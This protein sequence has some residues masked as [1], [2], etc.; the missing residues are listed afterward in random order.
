MNPQNR[1]LFLLVIAGVFFWSVMMLT[2]LKKP[3]KTISFKEFVEYAD[4]GRVKDV[5]IRQNGAMF[6]KFK[7]ND[8]KD[9]SNVD[10][11]GDELGYYNFE[12]FVDTSSPILFE[13]LKRNNIVPNYE[14]QPSSGF[15]NL[16]FLLVMFGLL[17]WVL[18]GSI[19]KS[20]MG[21]G[22]AISTFVK[23]RVKTTTGKEKRVLF[24]DVAGVD[25]AKEE[26]KEVV[27]FLKYPS[28]FTKLGGR[29]PKGVLL[30]GPPGTGKTLLARAV[31]G[32]ANVPFFFISGSDFVEMFVGVG[33]SRVRELF[34]QGKKNAP[35]IIFIDEIDAVGRQRGVGFSGG[36]DEREQTLNQML[37]EM[38]G[39]DN[40]TGVIVVAATNRSDVLDQALLRP[41]RFDRQVV[42][43]LP[44]LKGREEIFKVHTAKKPLHD[45]VSLNILA[46][47]TPGFS[48]ADIENLVNESALCAARKNRTEI[49]MDDFQYAID[50]VLMGLERKSLIMNDFEKKV[51]AYHEAGHA[52]VGKMV[53][54]VDPIHKVTIIPRGMALGVTQT[55]PEEDR[56]SLTKNRAEDNIAF[57]MGGRV[58]EELII[59]E[60][61]TGASN[62]IERATSLARKMICEW[63]LSKAMGPINYSSERSGFL[64]VPQNELS[65]ETKKAIEKEVKDII[66]C[67]YQ[68][69]KEILTKNINSL[70]AIALALFEKETITGEEIDELIKTSN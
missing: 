23:S 54:N 36:H 30:S 1:S 21:G 3:V 43:S 14:L 69:A 68:R 39:F 53:K 34:E 70:H 38:D 15:G 8:S 58:A 26:L 44:T 66:D 45:S 17:Y 67:N 55:L 13:T 10:G 2:N 42:V 61:T 56:V 28:K 16:I 4:G 46:R 12:T 40:Q 65:D 5:T 31:A 20:G 52:L 41:G 37:V 50:R 47:S 62:D 35:C 60:I 57:L 25:E 63:G 22:G 19:K 7:P 18:V 51:T 9:V 29:I 11:Y 59:G 49:Y 33:A 64:G 6:G 32:E 48:G 24:S 27:E